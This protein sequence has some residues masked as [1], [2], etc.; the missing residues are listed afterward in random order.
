[1]EHSRDASD[2]NKS[3]ASLR[4]IGLPRDE[5]WGEDSGLSAGELALRTKE[6]DNV[7]KQRTR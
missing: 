3:K 1:M 2:E 7:T 5:E 4:T 6:G